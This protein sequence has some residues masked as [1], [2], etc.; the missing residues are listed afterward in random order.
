VRF[1][2]PQGSVTARD[3]V[4]VQVTVAGG[5]ADRMELLRDGQLLANLGLPYQFTWNLSGVAE[6]SYKLTARAWR[7]EESFTSD[8]LSVTVDKTGPALV[9]RVPASGATDVQALAP[10]VLGFSEPLLPESISPQGFTLNVG[11]EAQQVTPELS[12]DGRTLTLT[13]RGNLWRARDVQLRFTQPPTDLAGNAVQGV[14]T[15]LP[16]MLAS[17]QKL[18]QVTSTPRDFTGVQFDSSGAPVAV[19]LQ[20]VNGQSSIVLARWSG[21]AWATVWQP[22]PIR[23]EFTRRIALAFDPQGNPWVAWLGADSPRDEVYVQRWTGSAWQSAGASPEQAGIES[24]GSTVSLGFDARGI[25]YLAADFNGSSRVKRWT[26]TE[27]EDLPSLGVFNTSAIAMVVGSGG[28][29]VAV[30][31]TPSDQIVYSTYV[32]RWAG[33]AWEAVGPP[34]SGGRSDRPNGL[35]M[36]A[37]DGTGRPTVAYVGFELDG[38]GTHLFVHRLNDSGTAWPQVG[39]SRVIANHNLTFST[40]PS[41]VLDRSGVPLVAFPYFELVNGGPGLDTA[42]PVERW[43]GSAWTP[44]TGPFPEDLWQP[45]QLGVSAR[46]TPVALFRTGNGIE[47]FMRLD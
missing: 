25:A 43:G 22:I 4:S 23:N 17:W 46:D 20:H 27:W 29:I 10:I 8:E 44:V 21:Q 33:T 32:R 11:G 2:L 18:P 19:Y 40:W 5:S 30:S 16:W 47:A 26:G 24:L 34:F 7:G 45:A 31:G 12:A 9:S 6:G 37:L 3:A 42:Y 15:A 38:E 1:V 35:T 13:P 28:P 36:L 14:A 39:T 41:M